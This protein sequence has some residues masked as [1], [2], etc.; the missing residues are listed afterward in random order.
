MPSRYQLNLNVW[1]P[2]LWKFIGDHYGWVLQLQYQSIEENEHRFVMTEVSFTENTNCICGIS[3]K[4]EIN[5][6]LVMSCGHFWII[7][8]DQSEFI[9]HENEQIQL[10]SLHWNHRKQFEWGLFAFSAAFW[11]I[12]LTVLLNDLF[13][14]F[15]HSTMCSRSTPFFPQYLREHCSDAG[16]KIASRA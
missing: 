14:K 8:E 10:S 9:L 6:T 5:T 4:N 7:T 12:S 11:D 13:S 15:L 16:E 2:H 3:S 1:M